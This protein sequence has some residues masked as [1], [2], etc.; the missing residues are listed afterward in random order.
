VDD[1]ACR[2]VWDTRCREREAE[3]R[4]HARAGRGTL[5]GRQD[6]ALLAAAAQDLLAYASLW[7]EA[8]TV[9]RAALLRFSL[10]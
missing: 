6:D 3:A 10:G 7:L 1:E 8:L 5:L 4:F 9:L 2:H